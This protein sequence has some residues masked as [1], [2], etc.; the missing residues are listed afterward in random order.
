M[1]T[2]LHLSERATRDQRCDAMMGY[3]EAKHLGHCAALLTAGLYQCV[4]LVVTDDLDFAYEVTNHID[5]AWNDP[6]LAIGRGVIPASPDRQR[7]TSVGDILVKDNE[8]FV[9]ASFGFKS[10]MDQPQLRN[11][12]HE[13]MPVKAAEEEEPA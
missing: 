13:F 12:A 11:G 10:L 7:S 2:V 9:V 1:I 8:Y 4:A 5:R 6:E 3:N